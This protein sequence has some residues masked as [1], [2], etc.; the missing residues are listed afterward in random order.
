MK[1]PVKIDA[2]MEEWSKDCKIDNTEPGE[3]LIRIPILHGKYINIMTHHSLLAKKIAFEY[4]EKRM[5]KTEYYS[6]NL[7]NPEDLAK[8]GLEPFQY[9][10]TKQKVSE[11]IE[12]DKELISILMRKIAHE[13]I[14]EYCKSILK[15]LQNRTWQLRTY[16][17]YLKYTSGHG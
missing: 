3:E 17:D 12:T 2:L 6:G 16:I 10:V 7:N 9:R 14:V 13:E 11:Y 4:N 1:A 8:Y 5:I 15:E